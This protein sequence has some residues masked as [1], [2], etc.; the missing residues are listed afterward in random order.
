MLPAGPRRQTGSPIPDRSGRVHPNPDFQQRYAFT[1]SADGRGGLLRLRYSADVTPDVTSGCESY[2]TPAFS[3]RGT[4]SGGFGAPFFFFDG[5]GARSLARAFA[6]HWPAPH[7]S[8]ARFAL[9]ATGTFGTSNTTDTRR[10]EQAD[11]ERMSHRAYGALSPRRQPSSPFRASSVL[12]FGGD[13]PLS[14]RIGRD[15]PP[16]R[17]VYSTSTLAVDIQ[18]PCCHC[19]ACQP[20][21]SGQ[22]R[23]S[24]F[25]SSLGAVSIG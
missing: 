1:S 8:V 14:W 22:K 4:N 7:L 15:R 5:S 21:C 12:F 2:G 18:R 24:V 11:S 3:S 16:V 20:A 25:S 23:R 19:P 9:A 6:S 10:E 17:R 13:L